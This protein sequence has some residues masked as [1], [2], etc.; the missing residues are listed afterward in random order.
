MEPDRWRKV[1]DLY[2][3][4]LEVD[5]HARDALLREA[6]AGDDELRREVESLLEQGDSGLLSRP[7]QLGAYRIE[8]VLGSGGMGTVYRGRDT[9]LGRAVAIKVSAAPFQDRFER[10]ARAVAALNHPHICTVYR[11]EEHT[12]ELQSRQY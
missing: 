11:S 12:S 9:R 3:A 4:A 7:L 5:Q 1:E 6:C 8:G 10:E 2:H